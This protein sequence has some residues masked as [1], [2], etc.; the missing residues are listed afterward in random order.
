MSTVELGEVLSDH[1]PVTLEGRIQGEIR[2]SSGYY[3]INTA[4]LEINEGKEKVEAALSSN[5]PWLGIVARIRREL[6]QMGKDHAERRR[7][8]ET[9]L[10]KEVA[11]LETCPGLQVRELNQLKHQLRKLQ[12]V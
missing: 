3:K 2:W 5:A 10:K 6:R 7:L 8:E 9:Q 12:E 11:R 1:K 4:L